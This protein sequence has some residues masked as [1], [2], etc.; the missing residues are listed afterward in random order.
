M[1]NNNKRWYHKGG[2]DVPL[3]VFFY[4][5]SCMKCTFK[6]LLNEKLMKGASL[7]WSLRYNDVLGI[8]VKVHHIHLTVQ[9]NRPTVHTPPKKHSATV[10]RQGSAQA[11]PFF[12]FSSWVW[13]GWN[14][15]E[16]E[17]HQPLLS[18]VLNLFFSLISHLIRADDRLQYVLEFQWSSLVHFR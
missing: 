8:L 4:L 9:Q 15:M 14:Q 17:L 11:H 7:A 10:T 5:E 1:D 13:N 3:N 18:P 6:L 12:F 16:F 2:K